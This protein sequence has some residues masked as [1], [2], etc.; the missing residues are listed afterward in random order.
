[1]NVETTGY[2]V[3]GCDGHDTYHTRFLAMN[4]RG[5]VVTGIVCSGPFK[6]NTVRFD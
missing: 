6:D 3:W 4:T 5:Q 1:M 2:R